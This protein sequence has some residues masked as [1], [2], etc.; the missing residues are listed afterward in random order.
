KYL[1]LKATDGVLDKV[2]IFV[3]LKQWDDSNLE[4][5][6]FLVKQFE[7]CD[8]PNADLFVRFI[9]KHGYALVL[10]DG[11]DEVKQEAGRRDKMIHALRDFS[12]QY[13][14]SQCVITCR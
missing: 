9:L 11:L 13:W 8:F 6:P 10:F 7:I 1:A 5:F 2:P 3:S 14:D 12:D 4:L